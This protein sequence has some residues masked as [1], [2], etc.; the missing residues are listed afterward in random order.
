[1]GVNTTQQPRTS[2][3][4]LSDLEDKIIPFF[5]LEEKEAPY[6]SPI[7][8]LCLVRD[9]VSKKTCKEPSSLPTGKLRRHPWRSVPFPGNM[10]VLLLKA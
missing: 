2:W 4:S 5:S 8:F 10:A 3:N 7:N 9:G 1:M 6:L